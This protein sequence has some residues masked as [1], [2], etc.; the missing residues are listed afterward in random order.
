MLKIPLHALIVMVGPSGA[1]KTDIAINAFDDHEIVSLDNIREELTGDVN[2][3]HH[4]D[5]VN[6]EFYRRIKLK[7]S[8]GE[9]VVADA[10]HV[11]KKERLL[12][13][14]IGMD[15]HV[16]I[17]YIVVD[18]P[19]DEKL[20]SNQIG[21]GTL[22]NKEDATFKSNEKDIVKGDSM[23]TVIDSR[24]VEVPCNIIRSFNYE[25][26]IDDIKIR[27]FNN[28]TAIGDVHG[29]TEDFVQHI[30]AARAVNNFIVQLGDIV[31]YGPDSVGCVD[32]M[33][34]L[35]VNGDAIFIIGN[36]EAKL[37]KYI[38]QAKAGDIR[39]KLKGGIVKTV[40]QL[41]KLSDSKRALFELKFATLM[42]YARH[43]VRI[44]NN[45]F[46]H[47]S[48]TKM[49]R[50]VITNRLHGFNSNRAIYGEIDQN[51][52]TDENGFPNR[53]YNWVDEI[54]EGHTSYVGHAYLDLHNPITKI[55]KLGGKAIFVDTGSGKE[56]TLS[57]VDIPLK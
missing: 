22:I 55:G 19:L 46:V 38:K 29:M 9:R 35:V 15:M 3:Y 31:D 32:L 20:T 1:G 43:H 18:R 42:N 47:A 41:D 24:E 13:T 11:K 6:E 45:V 36:H 30:N 57:S 44:G 40:E 26:I 51:N 4:E 34:R 7:L 25:G 33:Y 16:P 56:G 12:T 5:I 37:E 23:A 21:D 52:S 8:I 14:M 17:Y 39:I 49:M 50:D 53:Q 27:G 48:S 10:S 2:N 54:P 28:I